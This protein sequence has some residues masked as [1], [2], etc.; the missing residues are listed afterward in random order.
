MNPNVIA[1]IKKKKKRDLF[2]PAVKLVEV[3][4]SHA[5]SKRFNGQLFLPLEQRGSAV[6]QKARRK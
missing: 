6:L 2:P 5:G 3:R 1:L 4:E